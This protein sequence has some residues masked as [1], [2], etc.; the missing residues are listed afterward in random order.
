MFIGSFNPVIKKNALTQEISLQDLSYHKPQEKIAL[1]VDKTNLSNLAALPEKDQIDRLFAL[2]SSKLPVV[3]TIVYTSQVS[4]LPGRYAWLGD[5][6]DHY[7]T[8]KHFIARSLNCNKDN[9]NQKIFP[10]DKFNIFIPTKEIQFHLVVDVSRNKMWFYCYDVAAE[11][12]FLLKTY[13]VNIGNKCFD[14]STGTLKA[15]GTYR[16]GDKV[17]VYTPGIM[18]YFHNQKVEMMRIFGTRWLP[19]KAATTVADDCVGYG[20]HGLP[21][22]AD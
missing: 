20:I 16:L 14:A 22:V 3:E 17:A 2:D 18:G 4:W 7:A 10:G 12:K 21:W 8:S 15:T 11:E 6:A 13:A 19:L 9:F 1:T 5:Y